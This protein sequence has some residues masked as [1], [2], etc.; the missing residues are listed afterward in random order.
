M[1]QYQDRLRHGEGTYAFPDGYFKYTGHWEKGCMH[2]QGVFFM[3][4]G[5]TYEGEFQN[6]EIDGVGLRRW[7]DGTTYS[8]QFHK[9][10]MHGQGIRTLSSVGVR[11][12]T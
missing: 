7:P 12:W 6:G 1:G 2:G 3:G 8:G 9:G 5:S 4:D 10:E 11:G